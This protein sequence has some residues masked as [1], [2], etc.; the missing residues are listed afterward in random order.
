MELATELA[1]QG[2]GE[3]ILLHVIEVIAGLSLEEEREFYKRLEL[4]AR[5]HLDRLGNQLKN[6]QRTWRTEVLFGNRA[7]EIV[8]FAAGAA[9]D[10]IIVTSPRLDPNRLGAGLASLSYKISLWCQCPVLLVK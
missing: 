6:Q 4:K 10:L 2:G 7:A 8:R 3:V 5:K 1:G 9:V